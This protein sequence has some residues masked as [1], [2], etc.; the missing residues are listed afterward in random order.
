MKKLIAESLEEYRNEQEP[1]NEEQI[2]ESIAN[3]YA[4][5][6]KAD[7]AAIRKFAEALALRKY[8][9]AP[10]ASSNAAQNLIKQLAAK[11]TKEQ[12]LV[13]LDKA[14]KDNFTGRAYFVY[15]DPAS[16]TGRL[17]AWK[18]AADVNVQSQFKSGGTA[19]KTAAGG[20]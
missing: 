4:K 15:A 2:N 5:L 6:N 10:G 14:A 9:P 1:L 19:G 12:L 7:E 16:K 20:V 17:L 3:Q 8:V 11:E 18:N 13:F